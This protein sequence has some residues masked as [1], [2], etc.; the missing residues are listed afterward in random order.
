MP[1]T[2]QPL[3]SQ[4]SGSI[5]T[6]RHTWP[7]AGP[8]GHRLLKHP[9]RESMLGAIDTSPAVEERVNVEDTFTGSHE[10]FISAHVNLGSK[11]RSSCLS[12]RL[13]PFQS[14]R[15]GSASKV[16]FRTRQVEGRA[17]QGEHGLHSPCGSPPMK[18]L[19]KV[20][21]KDVAAA[22]EPGFFTLDL[23]QASIGIGGGGL[24]VV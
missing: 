22:G 2:S 6:R 15:A 7:L 4:Y 18:K 14:L 20:L 12:A 5:S 21:N 17:G 13:A 1:S 24:R 8:P 9:P 10:I 19:A 16:L 11:A 23:G 3:R